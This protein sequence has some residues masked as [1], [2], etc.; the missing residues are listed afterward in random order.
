MFFVL[1]S[2]AKSTEVTTRRDCVSMAKSLDRL[3]T[4]KKLA[5]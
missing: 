3:S 5:K 4:S 1:V 2:L